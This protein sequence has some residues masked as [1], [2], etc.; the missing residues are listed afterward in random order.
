MTDPDQV[1]RAIYGVQRA[2]EGWQD[3]ALAAIS[4]CREE[5]QATSETVE[6]SGRAAMEAR[7]WVEHLTEEVGRLRSSVEDSHHELAAAAN[8]V[9][10]ST[11]RHQALADHVARSQAVWSGHLERARGDYQRAV[12]QRQFAAQQERAAFL[13]LQ[14]AQSEAQGTASGPERG[15]ALATWSQR[16]AEYNQAYM[17]LQQTAAWEGQQQAR[18]ERCTRA[19]A[20]TQQ[21]AELLESGT[22]H[23]RTATEAVETGR[24]R[25]SE[26]QQGA[27]TAQAHLSN[28]DERASEA[29]NHANRAD[30]HLTTA[31]RH[32]DESEDWLQRGYVLANDAA[33]D[34]SDQIR[35]LQL[36]DKPMEGRRPDGAATQDRGAIGVDRGDG[37]DVKGHFTG[38]RGYGASQEAQGLEDYS[39]LTGRDNVIH[40]HVRA[41]LPDRSVRYY[42]GLSKNAN[43]TYQGIEVKSGS[44]GRTRSQRAFDRQVDSGVPA[45]AIMR[46]EQIM[47]TSTFLVQVK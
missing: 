10:T 43:G 23:L 34:M 9:D 29:V 17:Q 22:T 35:Q 30:E 8:T 36:A 25:L 11:L 37:R 1:A 4:T 13:R 2:M 20:L 39:D 15:M 16:H 14:A 40:E 6:G 44:A 45:T 31:T 46:G 24:A 19:L 21:A 33:L 41:V 38:G 32:L 5:H 47:I 3:A 26:A 28:M 18:V 27:A 7:V 42:D 12:E